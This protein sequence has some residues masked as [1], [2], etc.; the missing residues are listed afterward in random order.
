[1]RRDQNDVYQR[2]MKVA[3]R[4]AITIVCCVPVMIAFAYLTR[5]YIYGWL[6]IFCFML[7]MGVAVAIVEVVARRRESRREAKK[8][9][10]KNKDV[11]K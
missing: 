9:L 7:I 5:R 2:A 11:F 1:M 8:L 4:I 3:K 10:N 6:Q